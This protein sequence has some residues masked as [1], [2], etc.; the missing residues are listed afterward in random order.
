M[1]ICEDKRHGEIVHNEGVYS[2][3][4]ACAALDKLEEEIDNHECE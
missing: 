3:C 2:G 4:P 1:T